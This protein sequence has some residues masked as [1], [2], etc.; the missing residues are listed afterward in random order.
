MSSQ[1]L[2]DVVVHVLNSDPLWLSYPLS[3]LCLSL[4]MLSCDELCIVASCISPN[5]VVGK[6]Y[7]KL[8]CIDLILKDFESR[9]TYLVSSS[10]SATYLC[11]QYLNLTVSTN[12][13]CSRLICTIFEVVY[14]LLVASALC[15]SPWPMLDT[16]S[17]QEQPVPDDMQWLMNN[18]SLWMTRRLKECLQSMH[19]LTWPLFKS[20]LKQLCWHTIICYFKQRGCFLFCQ[21]DAYLIGQLLCADP[22]APTNQN[23]CMSL[24]VIYSTPNMVKTSLQNSPIPFWLANR[25]STHMSSPEK[26]HEQMTTSKI[27]TKIHASWPQKVS[28]EIIFKQLNKYIKGTIWTIPPP[29]AVCSYLII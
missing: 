19:P 7:D 6:H 14:R 15:K 20:S 2:S 16:F 5:F 9:C 28:C 12:I 21:S 11:L 17:I 29:C 26:I 27:V 4:S 24:F 1:N 3:H 25:A 10:T 8:S 23:S 13:A 22:S 18:L